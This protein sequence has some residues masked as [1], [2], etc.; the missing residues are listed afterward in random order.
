MVWHLLRYL[1]SIAVPT[2]YKGY[3]VKNAKYLKVK[4]P[5]I[6]AL[7]HPNAILDPICFSLIVWPPKTMYMARGDAFKPGFASFFLESVGVVPIFRMRDGG[8]EGLKKNDETYKRV[9]ELLIKN[10]KIMIFAEG[11]CV[12]ERRLRPL[13][14]GVPRMV[15]SSFEEINKPDLIVLPVGVNYNNTHKFRSNLFFNI[16]EPIKIKDHIERYREHPART[17]N[18]FLNELQH[19]MRELVIHIEDP[20]NDTL[21]SQLEELLKRELCKK[22]HLNYKNLEHDFKITNEIVEMV[23]TVTKRSPDL[24]ILLRGLCKD[25]FGVLHKNKIR[26]WLI[27]PRNK[28]QINSGSLFL[29]FFLLVLGSPLYVIGLI[30]NYLP[31][32]LAGMLANK[33]AKNIE[34]HSS[35]SLASGSFLFLFN[36][37]ILFFISWWALPG[38]GWALLLTGLF[39]F[40]GWFSLYY[41]PYKQKA[42]GLLRTVKNKKLLADL[43]TKRQEIMDLIASFNTI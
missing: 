30:G 10:K 39:L 34:F 5:V 20:D 18:S 43:R 22:R 9:N 6:I 40:S 24:I 19:K 36:Y 32:K 27:D 7:N 23:N 38:L 4:G 2:F 14:K 33:L 37:I 25:Y 35:V 8:K 29:R 28:G 41:H 31:Y 42:F 12:H 21:V 26:D 15:F 11:L 16:G 3:Q 1:M 13:K 17:L